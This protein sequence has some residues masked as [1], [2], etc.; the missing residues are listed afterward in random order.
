[1]TLNQ[2]RYFLALCDARN[3]T[4]AARRCA[5]S[6]PSLTHAIRALENELGCALFFRKPRVEL[7]TLGRALRPHFQWIIAEIEKTAQIV[8]S[9]TYEAGATPAGHERLN[10]PIPSLPRIGEPQFPTAS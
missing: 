8:A 4:L 1:M 5:V 10:D 2:L 3:F 9:A 7:T 6:Q